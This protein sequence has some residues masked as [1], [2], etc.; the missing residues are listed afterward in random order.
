MEG[1]EA[2]HRHDVKSGLMIAGRCRHI[3]TEMG[4]GSVVGRDA[5]ATSAA[6]VSA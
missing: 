6:C 5:A 4:C 2:V 3:C 1:W